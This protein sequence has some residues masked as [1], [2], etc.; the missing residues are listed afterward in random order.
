MLSGAKEWDKGGRD[1][2]FLL[3]GKTLE[4]AERWQA[5]EAEKEPKLT[6]L[7]KEYI[8][9][10]RQAETDLHRRQTQ[11]QRIL[12]GA[13]AL[14]LI[15]LIVLGAISVWKWTEAS[16]NEKQAQ[17]NAK[18]AR[19]NEQEARMQAKI[20]LS[21]QLTVQ[22]SELQES[23]PEASLLVNVE[24]LQRAP[25]SAKDDARFA[26][27]EKL[28][29]PYHVSTQLTGHDDGVSGVDFSPDGKLLAS[30]SFN[31]LDNTVRLWDVKSGKPHGQ[32]LTHT[33]WVSDVEFSPDGKLLASASND[34]MVHL[35]DVESGKPLGQPLTHTDMVDDVEFSPDGK[36]L[37]S[38]SAED[39]KV[40]LWD[41]ETKAL[42]SDACRI[43]NRN[44]SRDEWSSFVG[45]EF[46]YER[47]CPNLPAGPSL[48]AGFGAEGLSGSL[49][50][51]VHV[52]DVFDPAFR[53]ELGK[54]W[55]VFEATDF[56]D[57]E[58]EPKGSRLSFTNPLYYVF[59]PTNPSEKKQ[60]TEPENAREW[61]SWFQ[62]HPKL[63]TSKPDPVSVGG[64]SGMQIDVTASSTLEDSVPL[65]T[66]TWDTIVARPSDAGWKE[67]YVI[68]DVGG[69]TV[70]IN[71]AARAGKFDAFSPKVQE[72]LDSVEWKGD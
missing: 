60:V 64:A 35:W 12:L 72:I 46:D 66:S 37:A 11:R 47:T 31:S 44:L 23:Q 58:T 61:L 5:K 27:M 70:I 10:S 36:L 17:A 51:G 6:S 25:A 40:L 49:S 43:A 62:R 32:P 16:S 19:A 24:A 33:S 8:L 7:Q 34:N 38:T 54:G 69:E 28:A 53:F 56:V 21:R 15:V 39:S 48:S 13:A 65:Y 45:A 4:E 3:R 22:S 71:I 68:V 20:A 52:A 55:E 26:L 9:A 1:P 14:V 57:M 63:D 42:V 18:E 29:R 67:R 41:I 59:D 2:S 50:K 30:V